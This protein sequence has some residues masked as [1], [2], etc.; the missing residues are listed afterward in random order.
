MSIIHDKF[1][2]IHAEKTGGTSLEMMFKQSAVEGLTFTDPKHL[3]LS[4]IPYQL[5]IDRFNFTIARNPFARQYSFYQNNL[6]VRPKRIA[7][8]EYFCN[9]MHDPK[10]YQ[11][12]YLEN[13][14]YSRVYQTEKFDDMLKDLSSRFGIVWC[15]TKYEGKEYKFDR[16]YSKYYSKNMIEILK[17]NEPFIMENFDY[18]F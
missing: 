3:T 15:E 17:K 10:F 8:E 2:F 18:E 4:N 11:Q 9:R 7:F 1:I 16:D 5:A 14:L 12:F 13:K 6:R